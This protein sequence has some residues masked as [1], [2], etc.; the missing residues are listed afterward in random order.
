M[1]RTTLLR[2]TTLV[3][4]LQPQALALTARLQTLRYVARRS[5]L[6]HPI[7][8]IQRSFL[9]AR[10]SE[11]TPPRLLHRGLAGQFSIGGTAFRVLSSCLVSGSHFSLEHGA[12][13][14]MKAC[15]DRGCSSH[16]DLG[17]SLTS[18]PS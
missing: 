14:D 5:S 17:M 12:R 4:R 1:T 8:S 16:W 7:H 6:G 15:L 3:R 11:S 18:G 13:G 2:L 10:L 9:R